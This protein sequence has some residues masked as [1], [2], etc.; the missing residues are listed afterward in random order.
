MSE[1][2]IRVVVADDVPEVLDELA[3]AVGSA[4]DMELVGTA[5]D[6]ADALLRVAAELP[7]VMVLDLRMPLLD[8]ITV[9]RRVTALIPRMGV[10]M[11]TAYPDESLQQDAA[12]A[13]VTR[14][15]VKGA[16][17]DEL[18]DAIRDAAGSATRR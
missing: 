17:A 5:T 8:G 10:V 13:G 12:W 1:R 11:H 14:Y 4:D 18:L 16:T 6:G 15:V 7:D 2:R 9:A 3:A